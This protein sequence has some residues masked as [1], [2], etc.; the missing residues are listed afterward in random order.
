MAANGI[1]WRRYGDTVSL[2]PA[3]TDND[4]LLTPFAVYRLIGWEDHDG[5]FTAIGEEARDAR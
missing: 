2:V 1:Y 3:S 4:P 5:T